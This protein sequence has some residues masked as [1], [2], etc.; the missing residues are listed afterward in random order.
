MGS[1]SYDE[2]PCP[3]GFGTK[4]GSHGT[5]RLLVIP[6]EHA[7]GA[8]GALCDPLNYIDSLPQDRLG[9]PGVCGVP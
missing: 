9:H 8:L 7:E 6:G 4:P 5:Y 1:G 2:A 3:H